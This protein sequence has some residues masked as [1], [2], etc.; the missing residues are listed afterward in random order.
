MEKF[1]AFFLLAIIVVVGFVWGVRQSAL[2]H[3]QTLPDLYFDE[4][5]KNL[6][7]KPT[8]D[9]MRSGDP[10][11]ISGKIVKEDASSVV[12]EF[13]YVV[14]P[15]D[16]GTYV[17]NYSPPSSDFSNVSLRLK[18]GPNKVQVPVTFKPSSKFK[19]RY[20]GSH[21][22]F[23]IYRRID[24]NAQRQVFS[25]RAVFEKEWRE[26]RKNSRGFLNAAKFHT[27]QSGDR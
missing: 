2:Q 4:A 13:T 9:E 5:R 18:P 7:F 24:S 27:R 17:I 11:L 14:D 21:L 10:F 1:L 26:P 16:R 15:G 20:M 19:R 25:R 12:M 23:Y 22:G 6:D 8:D 3:G